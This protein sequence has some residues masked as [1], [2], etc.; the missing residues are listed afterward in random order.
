MGYKTI[1]NKGVL[2]NLYIR[3]LKFE[4]KRTIYTK[5]KSRQASLSKVLAMISPFVGIEGR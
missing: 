3:H 5:K 1:P 4:K 2:S